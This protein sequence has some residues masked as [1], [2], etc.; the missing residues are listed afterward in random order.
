MAMKENM[1]V[2]KE[3]TVDAAQSAARAA[4]LVAVVSQKKLLILSEQEKIRRLYTRLGKIY[5]KD[6][7][8]DEEPDE[9]EYKPVCEQISDCYRSINALREEIADAKAEYHAAKYGAEEETG[10]DVIPYAENA[11]EEEP[12]EVAQEAAEEEL[13]KAAPE[14]AKESH[15]EEQSAAP[16][17]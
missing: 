3:K 7:V 11:A 12:E 14:A 17:E 8:T 2:L 13:E 15:V 1:E 5:Y 10:F 6:Y 4:K 16:E 9:A